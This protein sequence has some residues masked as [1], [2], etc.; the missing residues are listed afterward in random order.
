MKSKY[1]IKIL[2]IFIWLTIHDVIAQ[3][4]IGLSVNYGDRLTFTPN[5]RDLLLQHRSFTPTLVYAYQKKFRSD[6]SLIMGGQAGIAGYQLIPEL[7]DTLSIGVDRYPFVD[8]G[9]FVSRFELT[10]GKML[11]IGGRELFIGIGGGISYYLVF[12]LTTMSIF[13]SEYRSPRFLYIKRT[14]FRKWLY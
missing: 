6:F 3:S 7:G 2:I 1:I 8:Y 5:Y 11:H 14:G 4:S 12:P 13:V 9:I 10:P